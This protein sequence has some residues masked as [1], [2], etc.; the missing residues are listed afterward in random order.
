MTLRER[1]IKTLSV[2]AASW[3][4]YSDLRGTLGSIC[5]NPSAT[6][7]VYDYSLTDD[8]GNVVYNKK[9]LRGA[10][11]DDSK[12]DVFGIYTHS[13]ANASTSSYAFT[14]T[15]IWDEKLK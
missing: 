12:L 5:I 15:L 8:D 4:T 10:W 14:I 1:Y 2:G 7:T 13:I 9:G 6:T 11:I 3:N